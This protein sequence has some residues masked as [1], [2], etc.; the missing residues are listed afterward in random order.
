MLY[1]RSCFKEAGNRR[2][3]KIGKRAELRWQRK[4]DWYISEAKKRERRSFK[5]LRKKFEKSLK[6][7]LTKRSECGILSG[8]PKSDEKRIG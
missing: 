2:E 5:R 8:S 1:S 4:E 3:E 6:K 7:P